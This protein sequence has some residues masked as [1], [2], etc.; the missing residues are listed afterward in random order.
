MRPCQPRHRLVSLS[1]SPAFGLAPHV[2]RCM[3]RSRMRLRS[4]Q[5]G[6]GARMSRRGTPFATYE[7]AFRRPPESGFSAVL[8]S[9]VARLPNGNIHQHRRFFPNLVI[10]RPS[11]VRP[12]H[13][14]PGKVRC[15][16]VSRDIGL[17]LSATAP[18]SVLPP[19]SVDA[20]TGLACVCDQISAGGARGC[21]VAVPPLQHT[22]APFGV[23]LNL[24]F[25]LFSQVL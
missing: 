16:H 3:H 2:S 15:D 14:S 12:R 11:H 22:S 7:C 23:P 10:A 21:R 8:T 9:V 4:D 20:C 6:R 18:R 5:C 1:H 25:Q 13:V 17:C 24:A 19:M